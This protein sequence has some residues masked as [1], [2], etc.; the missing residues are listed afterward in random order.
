MIIAESNGFTPA[1]VAPDDRPTP[2]PASPSAAAAPA[3]VSVPA[4][5]LMKQ[6]AQLINKALQTFSRNIQFSVDESTGK[7]VVKV[8]DMETGDLIRQMPSQEALDIARALDRL[9][10]MLIRQK[11]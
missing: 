1:R 2:P 10:G 5:E 6:T 4:P 9:Q 7:S 8:V 3:P 11:A